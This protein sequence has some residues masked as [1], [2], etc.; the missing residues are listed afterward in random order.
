MIVYFTTPREELA[1]MYLQ[2]PSVKIWKSSQQKTHHPSFR[3]KKI[4]RLDSFSEETR[5]VLDKFQHLNKNFL[6]FKSLI[7]DFF[8]YL[9]MEKT[10]ENK[11]N[12]AICISQHDSVR[13]TNII[14]QKDR[15]IL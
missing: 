7:N 12:I 6:P 5:I 15:I 3:E 2:L 8:Y 4:N 9:F 13:T 14:I 1:I 11:F 10:S